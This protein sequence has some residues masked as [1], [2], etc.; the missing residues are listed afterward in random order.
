MGNWWNKIS[1]ARVT[2]PSRGWWWDRNQQLQEAPVTKGWKKDGEAATPSR[3]SQVLSW[4]IARAA[5]KDLRQW[6]EGL[7]IEA[8]ATEGHLQRH[9]GSRD[10]KKSTSLSP[11]LTWGTRGRIGSVASRETVWTTQC[12]CVICILD[13][14]EQTS[15]HPRQDTS[16]TPR[17]HLHPHLP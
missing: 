17:K 11:L 8:E 14:C 1:N 4:N 5:E 9:H 6:K 7:S 16:N 2:K 3:S 15:V 10:G 13:K 12:S